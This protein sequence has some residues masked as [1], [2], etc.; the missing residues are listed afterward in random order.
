MD[1]LSVLVCFLE[2]TPASVTRRC[3]RATRHRPTRLSPALFRKGRG[4]GPVSCVAAGRI[5]LALLTALPAAA[6]PPP[7][8]WTLQARI[9]ATGLGSAHGI[10]QVGR[11]HAGGPFASN[12]EFLM[13]TQAGHVLD[14]QR[15]LVAVD[16]GGGMLLSI[17]PAANGLV[18]PRGL[19][20]R[21]GPVGAPLQVYSTRLALNSARNAG[22]VTAAEPA[23]A[24]PRYVS[25]NNAFGR[26]WIANAPAG[27]RGDGTESV[28][29]PDGA[30]LANAPSDAA[31]GVFAGARTPRTS[32]A[33]AVRSGWLASLLN[34]RASPQLTPGDLG[35]GAFG[36]ALLGTSP[37]GSGFAVFAVVTGRGAVVQVHVQDGVDGLAPPGTIAV[38]DGDPGVIGIAFQWS[39][40]RALFVADARRDRIAV[41]H[42]GDDTRQF[43]LQR[44]D[45]IASPWLHEPVDLA[46]ALPE[47]A[48]PRFSSH[49]TLAGG[50]DLL[51]AN[52]G[53]GTLLRI[54]PDG[55]A[56]ARGRIL[57]PDG[58][59][60]QPGEL[61]SLAVSADGRRIWLMARGAGRADDEL[62][63]VKAFDAEGV[64]DGAA[65][66][67]TSAAVPADGQRL[68]AT[69]FTAQTGLG[70]LFNAHACIACHPGVQGASTNDAHF[71]RRVARLDGLTGRLL[72][73][74]GQ[75]NTIA[76]RH[77]LQ[78]DGTL[79]LPRQ[80]N[81]VS[82]RMPLAL[83]AAGRIDAVDEAAIEA[84]AVAK[85]DGIHGRVHR[86]ALP[87]GS[88][89]IGR[90]GWK[91]DVVNLDAMVADAFSNE[92]GLTS[93]LAPHAR[94]P[95]K[96][97]GT[98]ARAVAAY[99]RTDAKGRE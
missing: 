54:G 61:R 91:A 29:D 21:R 22:A 5:A 87:D 8:L 35:R 23:V 38:G 49:T 94:P 73:L 6:A 59:A 76:A 81:V 66:E 48:N 18:V 71:V 85:G 78:V 19:S 77:A 42:L 96:D 53:D 41:L 25:I 70:P 40:D 99:L 20:P 80:A 55:R 92:M 37:D 51:V 1:T 50:A 52:R 46:P 4:R 27:L 34:R 95:F 24:S 32:V 17:D 65:P 45:R 75:D 72:P 26:P 2:V 12:P 62:L 16:E 64:F 88:S 44:V 79:P 82:L 84:Q 36:T 13:Q 7:P 9:V 47:T 15:L 33:K 11:F 58:A 57:R 28:T 60:L 43:V 93:A 67:I 97:D 90:Y 14:P 63:E 68:F 74:N 3:G 31:G 89:R 98:M 69:A 56:L 30:P 86:I 39:P 10:R 83:V